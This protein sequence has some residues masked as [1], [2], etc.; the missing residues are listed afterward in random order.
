MMK[1][2]SLMLLMLSCLTSTSA[3]AWQAPTRELEEAEEQAFKR[4]VSQVA[5]SLV[6]IETVGGLDQVQNFLLGNGPTTG[7]VLSADGY[8]IS[9]SFNFLS[10]PASI[11]VTTTDGRRMTAK[12]IANDTVRSLTLLK[13]EADGL[14]PARAAAKESIKVGQWA[15]AVGRAL[16]ANAP[17]VSVGIVSAVNRVWGKA[18]QTDAKISPVNYGGVLVDV[19]GTV[20][21]VWVPL[22]PQ[23]NSTVAGVEWYD[24]GIGFAIPLTDVLATLDRLKQGKDLRAG[25]AGFTFASTDM[26]GGDT[27]IDR[28]RY[29]SPMYRAGFKDGDQILE[30]DGHKVTRPAQVKHVLG[31]KIEGD[32]LAITIKRGNE[33]KQADLTLVGELPPFEAGFLG[34]LPTREAQKGQ[35]TGEKKQ[36]PGVGV[37]WVYPDSPAAKIGLKPRDRIMKFR[38]QAITSAAQLI[39]QVSR[40]RPTEKA[41]V[42]VR[43]D[44]KEQTLEATLAGYPADVPKELPT[45]PIEAAAD[46]ESKKTVEKPDGKVVEEGDKKA[47]GTEKPRTGR[48]GEEVADSKNAWWAFVPESYNPAYGYSLLAW[49]HPPGDTLEATIYD[50]WKIEAERRGIVLLGLKAANVGSG[51]QANE[52]EFVYDTVVSFQKKYSID[53]GRVVLHGYDKSGPFATH[54]A[55]KHRDVFRG[56]IL[57]ASVI[58]ER[59]PENLPEYRLQFQLICGSKD[60]AHAF[61]DR[62]A[63]ALRSLKYPANFTSL[64]DLEH[65]YPN[66]DGVD[67][68]ARW[69]DS[70]DRL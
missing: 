58:S 22:S 68:M 29:D 14:V 61:L 44:G 35:E 20:L 50:S 55:F 53:A 51:W 13:V 56:L 59:P 42:V 7:L 4:A 33:T 48:F 15:I 54:L 25:L 40:V 37:R 6:R 32:K 62:N 8:V 12:V 43:R 1:I 17:N 47:D 52:A 60:P 18:I 27:K 49:L 66:A 57:A 2:A 70:L 65:R 31:G 64:P 10:K 19:D 23:D 67:A 36:E 45:S 30:L 39:D 41:V 34:V 26:F 9:S 21:G 24:S 11:L 69:I 63:N 16:D 38:D 46:G 5:P 28:V 3:F